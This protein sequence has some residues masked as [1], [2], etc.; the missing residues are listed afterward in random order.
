[1][2]SSYLRL[3]DP[4]LGTDRWPNFERIKEDITRLVKDAYEDIFHLRGISLPKVMCS[5]RRA[6]IVGRSGGHGGKRTKG[7]AV[8]VPWVHPS[9]AHLDNLFLENS[10]RIWETKISVQL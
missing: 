1:M 4:N 6:K 9:V 10:K 5:G 3:W 2:L 7:E 8:D